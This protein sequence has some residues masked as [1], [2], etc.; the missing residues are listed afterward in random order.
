MIRIAVVDDDRYICEQLEQML[1]EYSFKYDTDFSVDKFYSCE[2]LFQKLSESYSYN[3]IFLDIEFT[4]MSGIDMGKAIRDIL[5]DINTQIIFISAMESYAMQLFSVQPFD[6]LVK[7]V[8]KEKL[9]PCISKFFK[10]YVNSNKFF[11]YTYNNAKHKI[12]VNEILYIQSERKKLKLYTMGGVIECYHK[13]SDAVNCEL[14]NDMVIIR[15]GTAVNIRHIVVTDFETVVLSDRT[16]LKI[17][18][19][20]RNNVMNVL[21]DKIGGF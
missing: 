3:L 8:T 6:F 14:K 1:L 9:Y 15:R 19:G 2:E 21:S 18:N 12:A 17:S 5:G 10:F 4:D 7:P 11:T 13:F 16:K 20:Y